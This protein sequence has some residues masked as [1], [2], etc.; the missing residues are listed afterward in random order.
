MR[1]MN[2]SFIV[3]NPYVK[4]MM[5]FMYNNEKINRI[6]NKIIQKYVCCMKKMLKLTMWPLPNKMVNIEQVIILSCIRV[7]LNYYGNPVC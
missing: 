7:N 6:I 4:L 5:A 3:L 1:K 2:L